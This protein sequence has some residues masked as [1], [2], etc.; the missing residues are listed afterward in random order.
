MDQ[1]MSRQSRSR[2]YS[3]IYGGL[4]DLIVDRDRSRTVVR[5]NIAIKVD[6]GSYSSDLNFA[7]G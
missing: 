3:E 4:C 7:L 6:S 5:S 1:Y 2:T